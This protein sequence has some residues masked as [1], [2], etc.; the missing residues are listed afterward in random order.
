MQEC[1]FRDYKYRLAAHKDKLNSNGSSMR[2]PELV[3]SL[4]L[5]SKPALDDSQ[6]ASVLPFDGRSK[7]STSLSSTLA[8]TS[9]GSTTDSD[10][11]KDNNKTSAT[12]STNGTQSKL[13]LLTLRF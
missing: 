5:L 9:V 6:F 4:I 3:Y 2:H 13:F 7:L 1:H 8:S 12:P 10:S 11:N